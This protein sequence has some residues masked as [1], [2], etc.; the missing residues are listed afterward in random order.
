M[1]ISKSG[2]TVFC[3][4]LRVRVPMQA[5]SLKGVARRTYVYL[6]Q[7]SVLKLLCPIALIKGWQQRQGGSNSYVAHRIENLMLPMETR[8]DQFA[9]TVGELKDST[10]R[11]FME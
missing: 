4:C 1:K 11:S 7:A 6:G 10:N 2:N 8:S 5:A 3:A 9:H